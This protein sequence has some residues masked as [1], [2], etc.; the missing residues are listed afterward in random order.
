MAD[1]DQEIAPLWCNTRAHL[2]A[3][4]EISPFSC[5]NSTALSKGADP[6]FQSIDFKIPTFIAS[7]GIILFLLALCPCFQRDEDRDYRDRRRYINKRKADILEHV[8]TKPAKYHYARVGTDVTKKVGTHESFAA[9]D[10]LAHDPDDEKVAAA[11]VSIDVEG[12]STIVPTDVSS[13]PIEVMIDGDM[14]VASD[15]Q[16]SF[17][18][19]GEKMV[20]TI[21][22]ESLEAGEEVSWSRNLECNHCYHKDCISMWL[23]KHNECPVCRNDYLFDDWKYKKLPLPVEDAA[24]NERKDCEFCVTHGLESYRQFHQ[25]FK[26]HE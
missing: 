22:L 21:C 23:I 24:A 6:N 11:F 26:S 2:A 13:S 3:G 20:C 4:G 15:L 10:D 9:I 17:S 16:N 7:A 5:R 14:G 1:P 8:I 19:S 12:P 25:P 18:T